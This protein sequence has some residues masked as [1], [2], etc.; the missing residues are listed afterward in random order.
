MSGIARVLDAVLAGAPEPD[1]PV[2]APEWRRWL[3]GRAQ[4][5]AP[6]GPAYVTCAACGVACFRPH[7]AGC[8]AAAKPWPYCSSCG[9]RKGA[10]HDPDCRRRARR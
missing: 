8:P 6:T 3:A 1:D 2:T 9:A 4:G 7:V 5:P 10:R